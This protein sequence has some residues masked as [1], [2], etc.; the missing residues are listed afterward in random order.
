MSQAAPAVEEPT[1]ATTPQGHDEL[2]AEGFAHF[3]PSL[4]VWAPEVG[5]SLRGFI[6]LPR[7]LD[8]EGKGF[9]VL[10]LTRPASNVFDGGRQRITVQPGAVVCVYEEHTL[11]ACD[12]LLPDYRP[13][14][15]GR[16]MVV[17]AYEVEL[18]AIDNE[19]TSAPHLAYVIW[20]ASRPQPP[21]GRPPRR[22]LP[23]VT[24]ERAYSRGSKKS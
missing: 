14:G 7:Q 2:A 11:T 17:S 15:G 16:Q 1:T 22:P 21:L 9:Y 24:F 19:R 20:A 12:R 4:P 6:T 5:D 3:N 18:H 23:C 13:M 10:Q 8:P